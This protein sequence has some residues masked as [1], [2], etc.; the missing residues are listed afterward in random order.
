MLSDNCCTIVIYHSESIDFRESFF[1]NILNTSSALTEYVEDVADYTDLEW[2]MLAFR[3]LPCR[4]RYAAGDSQR[5][6]R[7]EN[8]LW[9]SNPGASAVHFTSLATR[10]I[11][12]SPFTYRDITYRM[13]AL[14]EYSFHVPG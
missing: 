4:P 9:P 1:S 2:K 11:W 12:S 14:F 13:S 6:H 7:A 10:H 8:S 5:R 3:H